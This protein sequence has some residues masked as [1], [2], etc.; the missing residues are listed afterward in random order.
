MT[1]RQRWLLVALLLATLAL[2][3]YRLD[4]QDVWWDEARNIDVASR[5]LAHIATAGELDIHPPVY[6]YLLHVWLGLAGQTAFAIRFLSTA[7]GVALVALMFALGR[8]VG[9][10]WVGFFAALGAAFLP[11]LLGEAQEARM[12]TMVL[13]WLAAAGIALLAA[14]DQPAPRFSIRWLAFSAFSA[15]ALLTHYSAVFALVALWAWAFLWAFGSRALP[16][17][18]RR[19]RL[20]AVLIAGVLTALFCLPGVP[21][22]LRQIP[23]YRN[24]NLV[25]PSIASYLADLARVYTLGEFFTGPAARVPLIALAALIAGGALLG[26]AL[27]LRG[28]GRRRRNLVSSVARARYAGPVALVLLWAILPLVA[29]YAAIADR[30]TFATRYISVALPAWLLLAALALRGWSRVHPALGVA[31][32]VA[33]V[34]ILAPGLRTDLFDEAH[35][36]DNTRG[37]IEWLRKETD[38]NRDIILVDQRYPFGFYYERWNN[39]HVGSPPAE[40]AG[41]TPA[42][43]LFVDLN[44]LAGRL[45]GLARGRSRIYTVRWWESDTD[46]RGGVPF[47]LSKFGTRL[48]E[49]QFRG[50]TVD[51]YAVAP[52]A[53]I[54]LT[55]GLHGPSADFGGQVRLEG[56]DFGGRASGATSTV[57]ETRAT[58]AASDGHVWTVAGWSRLPGAG[59]QAKAAL[60]LEGEDGVVVARDDRLLLNDRH[61]ALGEWSEAER[62]DTVFTLKPAPATPPG[63]YTLKLSVYDPQTLQ[64]LAVVSDAAEGAHVVLGQVELTRAAA[65]ADPAALPLDLRSGVRWGDVTLLGR[66]P[67]PAEVPPGGALPLDLYWRGEAANAA[68]LQFRLELAPLTG[69]GAPVVLDVPVG[70]AYPSTKWQAG[71]VVRQ[72]PQLVLPPTLDAGAYRLVARPLSGVAAVPPP[73]VELGQVQVVGRSHD[74]TVPA[75]LDNVSDAVFGAPSA[76]LGRLLGFDRPV[77]A[78]RSLALGLYWQALAAGPTPYAVSVQVLNGDGVLVAQR[79]QQPGAGAFPANTWVA[80]E[81]LADRYEVEIPDGLPAGR[82]TVIVKMYDPAT[83]KIVPVTPDGASGA[84]EF[85]PLAHVDIP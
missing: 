74:F 9:G 30:G 34:V 3:L 46:P 51:W 83:G 56:V 61:V 75:A 2:R 23:G 20:V 25:V 84:Q 57:A 37:M 45:T 81:V 44:T 54:E 27:S 26:V 53:E 17:R 12:Y 31:A 50:Y 38:P 21:V 1:A 68:P 69:A 73:E 65:P 36:R 49:V 28:Q 15:A 55:D 58:A 39:L 59:G 82:Y 76:P 60:Q 47:L 77:L 52:D 19:R 10:F 79:D 6:F 80:G 43:Y 7:F 42:Q 4:A 32:G 40:P 33:L 67:L 41:E 71:E 63:R 14:T 5:A 16:G 24:T 85:L 62:P 29:Y 13:A 22:A 64:P 70:G 8:R 48:G 35:F 11:F 78:G 66:G 18:S 72:S